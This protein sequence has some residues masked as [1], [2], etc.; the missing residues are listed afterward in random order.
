MPFLSSNGSPKVYFYNKNAVVYVYV[1]DRQINQFDGVVGFFP[2]PNGGLQLTG[3]FNLQLYNSF[4]VGELLGLKYRSVNDAGQQLNVNLAY[5][6]L[7]GL[8]VLTTGTF[9]LF[10]RDTTFLD[11]NT[12]LGFSVINFNK[13]RAGFFFQ[14]R[15]I[16]VPVVSSA[17][18]G[19]TSG[20]FYGVNL[21]FQQVDFLPNPTRG[22]LV[23]TEFSAGNKRFTDSD[24]DFQI[25][26][27]Q[28]GAEINYWLRLGGRFTI[29]NSVIG[30]GIASDRIFSNERYR[31][32]GFG[33]FR[34][35]NE[36]G[37]NATDLLIFNVEPRFL[38]DQ[39]SFLYAFYSNSHW[40]DFSVATIQAANSANSVGLGISFATPR[41]LLSLAYALG[42]FKNQALEFRTA[43]VHFGYRVFI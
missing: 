24:E 33:T 30:K 17:G 43:K 2:N 12:R 22:L 29:Y 41:G 14:N 8:P 7:F 1:K 37:L 9:D 10:R 32:G 11:L 25:P 15:S 18:L 36:E 19:S 6:F 20:N 4:K 39:Q 31:F 21:S 42:A 3:D 26:Q 35:F 34:G 27:Y 16:N 28:Y 23:R 5:P 13:L 38:L 40:R